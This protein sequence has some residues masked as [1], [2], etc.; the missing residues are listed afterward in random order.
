MKTINGTS[1]ATIK[2]EFEQIAQTIVDNLGSKNVS[3]D[4]GV[5][6]LSNI[7][8]NITAGE[9]DGFEYFITPAGEEQRPWVEGATGASDPGAPGATYDESNGVTWDLGEAGTLKNG[10]IYTVKFTVWPSQEAYDYIA[11]LNNGL[12]DPMPTEEELAAQGI[13]EKDG[14]YTLN[15]NTHLY[16]TFTDL[17]GNEYKHV[18]EDVV[19]EAMKLPTETISAQ[20]IWNN[21]I[22]RRNPPDSIKLVLQ[23]DGEDYLAGEDAIELSAGNEWKKG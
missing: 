21:L 1:T 18:T 20:K 23:K 19:S 5:P 4:D 12:V 9:A 10:W 22:D 6:S 14:K 7:S 11:D 3:V 15:T 2:S 13:E 17:D 16:T 8:A